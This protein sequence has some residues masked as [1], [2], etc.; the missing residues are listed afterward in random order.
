MSLIP[1][2][3]NSVISRVLA[4]ATLCLLVATLVLG[5]LLKHSYEANGTISS[6]LKGAVS[7]LK[8]CNDENQR[9]QKAQDV[10]DKVATEAAEEKAKVQ[11]QTIQVISQVD[12]NSQKEVKGACIT[13]VLNA[14]LDADTDRLLRQQYSGVSVQANPAPK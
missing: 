9:L 12:H 10:S 4:I 2:P 5:V 1:N 14:T 7:A 3:L 6:Q 13:N 8:V 11:D